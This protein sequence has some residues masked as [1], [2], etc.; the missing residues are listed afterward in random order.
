MCCGVD[1]LA[2]SPQRIWSYLYNAIFLDNGV[3]KWYMFVELRIQR[4]KGR[5]LAAFPFLGKNME[6]TQ[7]S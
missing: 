7:L 4:T 1:F 6:N 5:Q 3:M 2:F